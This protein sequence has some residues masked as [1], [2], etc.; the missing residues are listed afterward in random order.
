MLWISAALLQVLLP[1]RAFL[2][3]DPEVLAQVLLRQN[4]QYL[5]PFLSAVS[6]WATAFFL[7]KGKLKFNGKIFLVISSHSTRTFYKGI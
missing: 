3:R 5:V 2:C 4:R 7:F 1:T 6:A